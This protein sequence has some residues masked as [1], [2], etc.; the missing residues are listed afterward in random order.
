MRKFILIFLLVIGFSSIAFA[1][2]RTP[3]TDPGEMRAKYGNASS[4]FLETDDGLVIHYRDEGCRTCPA[5]IFMH[6]A[7]ASLHNFEVLS[8]LLGERYRVISYD[9]PGH[10]LSG[11][12]PRDDYSAAGLFSAL[13]AVIEETRVRKFTL[14]G[15]SMG[16]WTA[17][18]YALA[19]PDKIDSLILLNASGA[20]R[21]E[22]AP[23]A[24]IYLAARILKHPVGRLAARHF[25]PRA[26]VKR[27][28]IESVADPEFVTEVM[29]D[30]YWEL[31]RLPSY[32]RAMGIRAVVD[33]EPAYGQRLGE[34]SMPVLIIWGAKDNVVPPFNAAVFDEMIPDSH[35]VM[36]ENAGH[37]P[38]EETPQLT[39]AAIDAFLAE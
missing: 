23:E 32:R 5:I 26:I 10:G 38:M 2:L 17:W 12:H 31:A 6:G 35:V 15:A 33:R 30:R 19:H 13:D 21:P 4:K 20:P 11:E 9:H 3:D 24:K 39:A 22:N 29:V 34:L 1:L 18:R 27:S 14:A 28:A 25:V 8:A 36:I 16:G 37:I 7:N